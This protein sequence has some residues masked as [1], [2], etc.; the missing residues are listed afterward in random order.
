[1]SLYFGTTIATI[2]NAERNMT[3]SNGF[4]DKIFG[5]NKAILP[6]EPTSDGLW[7]PNDN[8]T[9]PF[10]NDYEN[11]YQKV[12]E[13]WLT[14][15]AVHT[16]AVSEDGEFMAVAGGYLYDNEIHIYRYNP[17]TRDYVHVWDVGDDV[18]K[19]DIMALAFGDTDNNRFMEVIAASTDGYLYVFE[20]RHVYDPFTNTENQFDFV[21]KSERLGRVFDI[22]VYDAD[23]D[24]RDDIIAAAWDNKIHVY[25]YINHSGYPFA[26]EHW[27]EYT[28]TWNSG[29]SID[30]KVTSIVVGDTNYNGL[31]EIVAGTESG[32][33]Y[34]F[35]N[36]G[37][38]LWVRGKPFPLPQDN[39]YELIWNS[40]N[41]IWH[42]IIDMDIGDLDSDNFDEAIIVAQGQGAYVLEY[43]ND[44]SKYYLIKLIRPLESW[45]MGAGPSGAGHPLDHY[46]DEMVNGTNVYYVESGTAYPEP[47][48]YTYLGGGAVDP[49]IAIKTD[50]TAMV[51]PPDGY[52]SQFNATSSDNASAILDFGRDEEVTGNGNDNPD[53]VVYFVKGSGFESSI[54]TTNLHFYLSVDD[55]IYY[56]IPSSD[57]TAGSSTSDNFTVYINIDDVLNEYKLYYARYIQINAT[58]ENYRYA[59]DAIKAIYLYR[60]MDTALSALAAP[61]YTDGKRIYYE[62]IAYLY[63]QYYGKT[64]DYWMNYLGVGPVPDKIVL[65]TV[66]GRFVVFAYNGTDYALFWESYADERFAIDTNIWDLQEVKTTSSFPS[67]I[68]FPATIYGYSFTLPSSEVYYTHTL[69][70]LNEST[71]SYELI[72]GTMNGT[73]RVFTYV[74]GYLYSSSLTNYYFYVINNAYDS[75]EILTFAF[76]DLMSSREGD[77]IVI[78]SYNKTVEPSGNPA[79]D[80]FVPADVTIK[81]W[82]RNPGTNYSWSIDLTSVNYDTSQTMSHVL[83]LSKIPPTVTFGD[84]DGD[85]DYDMV[86]ANGLVYLYENIGS[87]T[88]PKFVL[89]PGYFDWIN[90]HTSGRMFSHPTFRDFDNDGDFDLM[91]AY[92]NKPGMTYYENIGT[93][94]NPVWEEKMSNVENMVYE[95]NLGLLNITNPSLYIYE[96]EIA[97][98]TFG[99]NIRMTA[100]NNYT[101]R[102]VLFYGDVNHH[103]AIMV[104]TYPVVY[105]YDM[106]LAYD[107]LY[108]TNYGGH[109]IKTWDSKETL[110]NWTM[111]VTTGDLDQD[112]RN[113]VIVGDYDNNIY[114]FEHLINNTYK[115]AFRS[116]DIT[117]EIVTDYS[118][119]AWEE[120]AGISGEFNRT[121]W[122]HVTELYTG[123]DINHNGLQEI[124]A[125]SDLSIYVFEQT[126]IDDRYSLM[127]YY[128]LRY[129]KWG[130]YLLNHTITQITAL[131]VDDDL[132][133]NGYG[134]IIVA[135]GP[136]LFIFEYRL[137]GFTEVFSSARIENGGRYY[138]PGNPN[139]SLYVSSDF[140]L[141]IASIDAITTADTDNDGYKEVIIGGSMYEWNCSPTRYGFVIILENKIGYY[142]QSDF[143]TTIYL[144][145]IQIFFFLEIDVPVYD[146]IVGDQDYDGLKEIIVGHEE[147]I[148]IYEYTNSSSSPYKRTKDITSS[149]NYPRILMDSSFASLDEYVN[150]LQGQE[151]IQLSNGTYLLVYS[152]Y[153]GSVYSS[154]QGKHIKNYRLYAKKADS[155]DDLH[156]ATE[157]QLIPDSA[158]QVSPSIDFVFVEKQPS[159]IESGGTIWITWN[160][161][162]NSTTG[163]FYNYLLVAKYTSGSWTVSRVAFSSA[164]EYQPAIWKYPTVTY[165]V[166][167]FYV[168]SDYLSYA[169]GSVGGTWTYKSVPIIGHFSSQRYVATSIDVIKLDG[170]NRI[171]LAFAGQF[172]NE[173]KWDTDIWVTFADINTTSNDLENWE[174]PKRLSYETSYEGNPSITQ[175]K[176][177]GTILVAFES[178]DEYSS[179]IYASYTND[180][181][182]SWSRLYELP[183]RP[184]FDIL[185]YCYEGDLYLRAFIQ[186][187]WRLVLS[188]RAHSPAIVA[189]NDGGFVYTFMGYGVASPELYI[190][191]KYTPIKFGSIFVGLNPTGNWSYYDHGSVKSI[192]LGDSDQDQRNEILAAS[193]NRAVLFEMDYSSPTYQD[194][195]QVWDSGDLGY[196]VNDVAIGDGNGNGYPELVVAADQGNVYA[197]EIFDAKARGELHA[198]EKLYS[199]TVG[200]NSY[201]TAAGYFR[202]GGTPTQIA[203]GTAAGLKIYNSTGEEIY[204]K[205]FGSSVRRVLATNLDRDIQTELILLLSNGTLFGYDA[206]EEKVLWSRDLPYYSYTTTLLYIEDVTADPGKELISFALNHVYVIDPNTGDMLWLY[207][208]TTNI[209]GLTFGNFTGDSFLNIVIT[210]GTIGSTMHMLILNASSQTVVLKQEYNERMYVPGVIDINLDGIDD[211]ILYINDSLVAYSGSDSSELW[212]VTSPDTAGYLRFTKSYYANNDSVEDLALFYENPTK[213]TLIVVLDGIDGSIIWSHKLDRTKYFGYFNNYHTTMEPVLVDFNNDGALDIVEAVYYLDSG[214]LEVFVVHNGNGSI[215]GVYT[216]KFTYYYGDTPLVLDANSDGINDIAFVPRSGELIVFTFK[217]LGRLYEYS[218]TQVENLWLY[219]SSETNPV[220]ELESKD[221]NGDG[222]DDVVYITNNTLYAVN[223]NGT[224]LWSQEFNDTLIGL[225]LAKLT[226][227]TRY[228]VVVLTNSGMVFAFSGASN[229][230]HVVQLWNV[231]YVSAY[232]FLSYYYM[233]D[234]LTV[235]I[236]DDGYD[237]VA[238]AGYYSWFSFVPFPGHWNRYYYIAF[239]NATGQSTATYTYSVSSSSQYIKTIYSANLTLDQYTDIVAVTSDNAIIAIQGS[240]SPTTLWITNAGN[241]NITSVAIANTMTGDDDDEIIVA[242]DN[243]TVVTIDGDS[244][245]IEWTATTPDVPR[246]I[247]AGN[248]YSKSAMSIA[249]VMD[250]PWLMAYESFSYGFIKIIS[251]YTGNDLDNF[252]TTFARPYLNMTVPSRMIAVDYNGDGFDEV[253]LINWNYLVAFNRSSFVWAYQAPDTLI[254]T[255]TIGSVRGM[256]VMPSIIVGTASGNVYVASGLYTAS[257]SMTTAEPEIIQPNEEKSMM[258][259]F[260]VIFAVIFAVLSVSSMFYRKKRT[261]ITIKK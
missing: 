160:A 26:L 21:W 39:S 51:G 58:D 138:L 122:S 209:Q 18:I 87:L 244:K 184:S 232:L 187:S 16:I 256:R 72:I 55:N 89:V 249:V 245:T 14:K 261:I 250:H 9:I 153:L 97:E 54:N 43:N 95:T 182:I 52:Y 260:I 92:A 131:S 76:A 40:T 206:V 99:T 34:I 185:E 133:A 49:D 151:I 32:M 64:F 159:I 35:E 50:N 134:E 192:A 137:D 103:T 30:S 82:Y 33:V 205:N 145:N 117:H 165:E 158:Y 107:E 177:T 139:Y 164:N 152:K 141:S 194:Y 189:A 24:G 124:V 148:T 146:I 178:V 140:N 219:K 204:S 142:S 155:I 248:F 183:T 25:E 191:I 3:A 111:T 6:Y 186:S 74:S 98:N 213:Y 132:D 210:N 79:E 198:S 228:D 175:L 121:I 19:G 69:Y 17:D 77:E 167:I 106:S 101:N 105:R 86:I 144:N 259:S 28:E 128:D 217:H 166:G 162:A 214:G 84:F 195:S 188:F 61:L 161:Y 96:D 224:L 1:M 190:P 60:P 42:N 66:D 203:I 253:L 11:K 80:D 147:G 136:V 258:G 201:E 234:I 225:T 254:T 252:K 56:E 207:N 23:L 125:V 218:V 156:S 53:I 118:P 59:I 65:G 180:E 68:T 27:I 169:L 115:R 212:N 127:W 230:T 215:I 38:V 227:T 157:Y 243:K 83:S 239:L 22:K 154:S 75:D 179:T 108:Y 13:P 150:Q 173:S 73:I 7:Y 200:S 220:I 45:E 149:P 81:L 226:N 233:Y 2:S 46:I 109:M 93:T 240:L 41:Y 36:N 104:A 85:G 12:W 216:A 70:N 126:G 20:Q 211:Y 44:T 130:D 8:L 143:P 208:T 181:G 255:V 123:S 235:Q 237:E 221:I 174:T 199:L 29:D 116:P 129:S 196:T 94:Q 67:W 242:Y 63:Q 197:Y 172:K 120:L 176:D 112:G 15:A 171:A 222:K 231:S 246:M 163:S 47:I 247:M 114:V 135:A 37:T 202:S 110:A 229:I 102:I 119:Y 251:A 5:E 223:S 193:E 170:K 4:S 238:V 257:Y 241:N 90:K 168:W 236:N 48:T 100:Y 10:L 88:N 71:D 62:H 78:V 57:I 31:P 113:E 91:I